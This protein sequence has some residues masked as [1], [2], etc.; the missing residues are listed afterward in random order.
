MLCVMAGPRSQAA[1]SI[2]HWSG[3]KAYMQFWR[4][5]HFITVGRWSDAIDVGYAELRSEFR[6]DQS[7]AREFHS[8]VGRV[9]RSD[10]PSGELR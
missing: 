2:L 10:D 9:E 3:C 5:A 7:V 4:A 6:T 8:V 1:P